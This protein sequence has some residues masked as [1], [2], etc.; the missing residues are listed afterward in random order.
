[1][2]N[3]II[4][5][6]GPGGAATALFLAKAGIPSTL[7]DK[8]TF[9]RDKVCG[10]ALSGKVVEV[11]KK[12][13]PTLLDSFAAQQ[14]IQVG[15][16]GVRFVAPNGKDLRVPFQQTYDPALQR[17]PGFLSRRVHFD[18]FLFERAAAHPLVTV[19]TGKAVD[20]LEHM[21]GGIRLTLA[22]GDTLITPLVIGADGAHSIVAKQL[23]HFK[24]EPRHYCAGIRVY[25]EG[26]A[27]L[28]RDNFIELQ[29]LADVLPGYL[30]IF[31]LPNGRANVGLGIRSDVVAKRRL[32]LKTKLSELLATHPE[33]KQRFAH[34]V[35]EGPPQGFGLPL[36]SKR[37]VI[38]GD[39]YLLVGDAASLID[40]FT[41]EGIGNALYSALFAAQQAA[42]SLAAG[43]FDAAFLKAYDDA[44]YARL[45]GELRLGGIMQQLVAYPWLFNL[46]VNKANANATLRQTISV[47]FN[48]LELRA[49]LKSP[50]FYFK[51]LFN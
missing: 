11:L 43:R 18:H 37:R 8:S 30:W 16:W 4:I 6:A 31:P 15:S 41:G 29:F 20:K 39:H 34:A 44:T 49:Q 23:H 50:S 14:D 38:S 5:G 26:V 47:M 28:E 17:A 35:P 33:L 42:R 12:L 9:P 40:P 13:D 46:V 22:G 21:P 48:D 25:Y 36:G 3:P 19:L 2:N 24:L 32:N 27:N 45:W 7:I 1:V 10:D 51:L